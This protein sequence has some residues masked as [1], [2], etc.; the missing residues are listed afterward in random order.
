MYNQFTTH[1]I[2]RWYMKYY[3]K[4]KQLDFLSFKT[5]IDCMVALMTGKHT[6]VAEVVKCGQVNK[7]EEIPMIQREGMAC[8][9][10][11]LHINPNLDFLRK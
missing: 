3:R 9:R 7:Q 2:Q 6:H 8:P 1:E 5:G 10:T 11:R 4:N